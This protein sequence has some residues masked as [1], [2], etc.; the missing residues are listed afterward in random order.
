MVTSRRCGFTLIEL[1]VVIAIIAVLIGMLLPAVQRVREAAN[2]ASCMNNLK[3]IG[4]AM[5]NYHDSMGSLPSGYLTQRRRPDDLGMLPGARELPPAA[6]TRIFDRPPPWMIETQIPGWGWASLILPYIEQSTVSQRIDYTL[7]VESPSYQ[8]LR[9][10]SQ[11]IYTCPSDRET[12]VFMVLANDNKE[13]GLCATNSYAAS[14]G[15][16]NWLFFSQLESNG[17]FYRNSRIALTD[18]IKGTSNTFAVGERSAYFTKTPWAGVF[19]GGTARITPDAPVYS[20]IV[21]PAPVMVLARIG[22]RQLMD[23]FS[24]PYDFFSPHIGA[25]QFAFAD[26]SVRPV[27]IDTDAAVLQKLASRFGYDEG[28]P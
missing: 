22:F 17:L 28:G 19:S 20:A 9:T 21:E 18:I 12:G 16:A 3:Q 25:V 13:L 10:L 1:L 14:Y 26:G 27:G 8:I 23:P 6:M 15:V 24:E 5:H 11:P 4:L 2:K 7:P